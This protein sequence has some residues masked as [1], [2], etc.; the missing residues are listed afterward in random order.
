MMEN[1]TWPDALTDATASTSGEGWS[2]GAEEA[3]EEVASSII[4]RDSIMDFFGNDTDFGAVPNTT[5]AVPTTQPID[6]WNIFEDKPWLLWLIIV[7][8]VSVIVGVITAIITYMA[9]W[10]K[11]VIRKENGSDQRI[12][13]SCDSISMFMWPRWVLC[14]PQ[15]V[16]ERQD[17]LRRMRQNSASNLDPYRR[18]PLPPISTSGTNMD[19]FH[20]NFLSPRRLESMKGAEMRGMTMLERENDTDDLLGVHINSIRGVPR[21]QVD[22]QDRR[23][24][25]NPPLDEIT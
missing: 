5:L 21:V 3:G 16:F 22:V 15:S 7:V 23:P 10:R 18:P 24:L 13:G 11:Q 2:T 6:I 9:R 14:C 8:G 4:H 25:P 20:G 19:G 1:L 12:V 17:D